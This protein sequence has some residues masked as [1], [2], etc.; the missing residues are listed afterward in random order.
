MLQPL[1]TLQCLELERLTEDNG[2]GLPQGEEDGWAAFTGLACP[3]RL[4][5]ARADGQWL[6]GFAHEGAMAEVAAEL[7]AASLR[8]PDGG[9]AVAVAELGPIIRRLFRLARSLPTAPLDSFRDRTRAL[10]KATE[11]E[12]LVV[13]RVGQDIFRAALLEYWGGACPLTGITHPRLL[14]AS[15]M[16]PWAACETDAERLDIHNGLLLAAHLDA[17]FDAGLITFADNGALIV[18]PGLAP[19]DRAALRLNALPPLTGL[20]T[21]HRPY[22]ASHRAGVFDARN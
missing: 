2:F 12:R 7:G 21:A 15:H 8:R 16:K 17:A 14:R 5:V 20:K 19:A 4:W 3:W 13:Q 18:S 11:A 22:L 9:T 10:P 6:V 1:T